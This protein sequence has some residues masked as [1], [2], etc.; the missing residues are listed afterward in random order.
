M[1]ITSLVDS[2]NTLLNS[3]LAHYSTKDSLSLTLVRDPKEA[4]FII[5]ADTAYFGWSHL[6][7]SAERWSAFDGKYTLMINST[8]W[9]YPVF[10]GFYPSLTKRCPGAFS[11]G[12]YLERPAVF[13]EKE[14]THQPKYLYSF[15]GRARTH[16]VR[17]K[18]LQ[19][20]RDDCP[21]I[22]IDNLPKRFDKFDYYRNYNNIL[23]NSKFV[24]CP[25]GFGASSIR[26]FEVMRAGRVPVIVSNK[27][28]SP[29]V[30]D[31]NTFAIKVNEEDIE[32][33]P[34]LLR[35]H[36]GDAYQRGIVAKQTYDKYFNTD[37]YLEAI[38]D[39]YSNQAQQFSINTLIK[40]AVLRS[41]VREVR[42]FLELG[43]RTRLVAARPP[44][45]R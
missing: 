2:N 26:L 28:I 3:L 9:P 23:F 12:Y 7:A 31:W 33:I 30:G 22:D 37:V 40:R 19:L 41:R 13:G 35:F 10:D 43:R 25:R 14:E 15:V 4:E 16:H 6:V 34:E 45:R 27:W 44:W 11:W 5:L 17:Q 36:E 39:F 18:L 38:V 32:C 24:L 42:G 20:D 29:P 8:D 21:C 1:Y